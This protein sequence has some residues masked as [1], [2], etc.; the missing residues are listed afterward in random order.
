MTKHIFGKSFKQNFFFF[1]TDAPDDLSVEGPD[2]VAQGETVRLFLLDAF[3]ILKTKFDK[4][5]IKGE[6]E[7]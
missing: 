1:P 7:V 3:R 6:P 2:S 5:A 4:V